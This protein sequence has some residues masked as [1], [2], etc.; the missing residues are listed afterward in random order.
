MMTMIALWLMCVLAV[1]GEPLQG[2]T[3]CQQRRPAAALVVH[4]QL[5]PLQLL[6]T[7]TLLL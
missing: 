6:L 2:L 3:S 7:M 5:L 4:L 1:M